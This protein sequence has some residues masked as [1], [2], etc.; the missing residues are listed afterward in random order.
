[1]QP[2][3]IHVH[4]L[5]AYQSLAINQ[6]SVAR[7]QSTKICRLKLQSYVLNWSRQ[8]KVA[9]AL[10]SLAIRLVTRTRRHV[11]STIKSACKQPSNSMYAASLIC[12][13]STS[14]ISALLT[15]VSATKRHRSSDVHA[16]LLDVLVKP[17]AVLAKPLA[18]HVKPLNGYV[19]PRQ[20]VCST[21]VH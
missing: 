11:I 13:K 4:A 3:C 14:E 9:A 17:L 10:S 5:L 15:R 2:V 21:K 19:V 8:Y 20:M 6:V 1:M 18:V 7:V 12:L 16:R